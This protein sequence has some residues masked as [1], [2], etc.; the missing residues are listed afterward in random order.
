MLVSRCTYAPWGF[1]VDFFSICSI[2]PLLEKRFLVFNL[3]TCSQKKIWPRDIRMTNRWSVG[4]PVSYGHISSLLFFR[5]NILCFWISGIILFICFVELLYPRNEVWGYSTH[6]V[7]ARSSG[8]LHFLVRNITWRL[9]V[10]IQYNFI[11]WSS[12]S[13]LITELSPFVTFPCLEYNLKTTV[14]NSKQLHTMVKHNTR[15]CSALEP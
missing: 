1:L 5:H 11:Q 14:W 3:G 4:A 13:W 12:T 8:L 7:V 15:K 9:M 2:C 6:L 10:G